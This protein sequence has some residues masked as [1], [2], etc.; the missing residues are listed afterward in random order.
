M[1]DGRFRVLAPH[2]V[3]IVLSDSPLQSS[4]DHCI[5]G[6]V[7][8]SALLPDR[9][10]SNFAWIGRIPWGIVVCHKNISGPGSGF[11]SELTLRGWGDSQAPRTLHLSRSNESKRGAPFGEIELS[12]VA[13]ASR[14]R[15]S[16][17]ETSC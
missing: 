4:E 9:S 13:D 16:I 17:T 14:L 12:E 15:A 7:I 8:G 6:L 3:A 5:R 2:A 11:F 10:A 1:Q